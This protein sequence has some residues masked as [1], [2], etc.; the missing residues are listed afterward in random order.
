MALNGVR[1]MGT[2]SI[3]KTYVAFPHTEYLINTDPLERPNRE[4]TPL[5]S[6]VRFDTCNP[7][8]HRV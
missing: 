4:I 5:I 8:A 1:E 2:F 6:Q 3:P 7:Q